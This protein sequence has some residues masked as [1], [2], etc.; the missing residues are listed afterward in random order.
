[1][2]FYKIDVVLTNTLDEPDKSERN[3]R[4]N[5]IQSKSDLFFD[6]QNRSCH[7][8]VVSI[9]DRKQKAVLCAA[10]CGKPLSGEILQA[11]FMEAEFGDSGFEMTEIS[12][13]MYLN[14]L[15][16]ASQNDFVADND[17]VLDKLNLSHFNSRRFHREKDFEETLIYGT[18]EKSQLLKAAES[19]LCQS[20]MC[21]E[22]ERIYCKPKSVVHMGHPVHYLLQADSRESQGKML[23]T[24]LTALYQNNRVQSRRYC[25]I[26][27]DGDSYISKS[28]LDA[29]YEAS[30]GGTIVVSFSEKGQDDSYHARAGADN[31]SCL[32]AAM[33][34]HR[35]RVLTV[36]CLPHSCEK[37]KNS[38]FEHLGNVTLV[39]I[40]SET[41]FGQRAK[42]YLRTKAKEISVATDKA[43]YRK[44]VNDKGY[45]AFDLDA[46]FDEW[47]DRKLKT[48]MFAQY[49]VLDSLTKQAAGRKPAGSAYEEFE[50]MIGLTEAKKVMGSVLD[51][52]KAQ[53]LFREKGVTSE[54]PAMH[55]VFTGNPGTAKTTVARLFAQIMKDNKL[56]SEGGLYEVGRSDLV[57]KYVGWT[58]QIVKQKFD[59]AMGSVL[60][61]DEAY[62]L[63]E[64]DGLYGDEAINTIVQEME[65]RRDDMIVIFAGYPDKMERFLQKNPGLRSRIGFHV[66]FDDYNACELFEITELLA[67]NKHLV[68][69][70]GVCEK[71]LEIY[72]FALHQEDFGNGRFARNMLERAIMN[73]SSRLLG[74]DIDNVT[75]ADV[76]LLLPAD[77][78]APVFIKSAK[79]NIGFAG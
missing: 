36:F 5:E 76:E 32:C 19:M 27:F 56:L 4:A 22:I 29:L 61:I 72:A 1:M 9:T 15:R 10:V 42:S 11:F 3:A 71:L 16:T 40:S 37:I 75:K 59:A 24:L 78:E 77:F 31:I 14:M 66:P 39:P 12:M 33:R 52:H 79:R 7:I 47:Y 51:F 13:D 54:R 8:A 18:K 26:S 69:G 67:G 44:I 63:V 28:M 70:E 46:I 38:F 48:T 50:K 49:A 20:S 73:Q 64:K 58:A 21:A 62:S 30:S 6:R 43:L 41:A 57:G 25:E 65:N 23:N 45:S 53:K 55:M 35:N 17:D 34:K 60:F 68:L 2:Q 74:T